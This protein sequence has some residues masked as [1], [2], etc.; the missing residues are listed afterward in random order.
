MGT[1]GGEPSTPGGLQYPMV[2]LFT[3]G[4]ILP[5]NAA[6]TCYLLSLMHRWHS[7]RHGRKRLR[8]ASEGDGPQ[9]PL[10]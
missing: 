2:E 3:G 7:C 10:L 5:Q 6:A 9:Y 1:K 4:M 8:P